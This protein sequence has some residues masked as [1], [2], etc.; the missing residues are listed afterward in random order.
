MKKLTLLMALIMLLSVFNVYGAVADSDL[1][2]SDSKFI[3]KHSFLQTLKPVTGS[4]IPTSNTLPGESEAMLSFPM[5]NVGSGGKLN[6]SASVLSFYVDDGVILDLIVRKTSDTTA[7]VDYKIRKADGSTS[8]TSLE[9]YSGSIGGYVPYS[10]YDNSYNDPTRPTS[11]DN[12]KPY[13][14]FNIAPGTGF[15]FKYNGIVNS[16]KWDEATDEF[17]FS[18]DGFKKGIVYDIELTTYNNSD[19]DSATKGYTTSKK[20]IS[21]LNTD[22]FTSVPFA[23]KSNTD[24]EDKVYDDY[25]LLQPTGATGTDDADPG[26]ENLGVELSLLLPLELDPATGN[27]SKV[28]DSSNNMTISLMLGSTGAGASYTKQINLENSLSLSPTAEGAEVLKD[29]DKIDIILKDM[30]PGIIYD[31]VAISLIFGAKDNIFTRSEVK[32][33]SNKIYTLPRYKII[34]KEGKCYVVFTPFK[35]V[36]GE[37]VLETGL[38]PTGMSPSITQKS[39]GVGDLT[40]PTRATQEN[41]FEYHYK[42]YF[43]PSNQ[44]IG[45]QMVKYK[46]IPATGD[47][48]APNNFTVVDYNLTTIDGVDNLNEMNLT[49]K[50]RWDIGYKSQIL[51]MLENS[52]TGAISVDYI[53]SENLTANADS[54]SPFANIKLDIVKVG[55]DIKVT[56]TSVDSLGLADHQA[57]VTNTEQVPLEFIFRADANEDMF[58]AEVDLE[59]KAGGRSSLL[60]DLIFNYPNIYFLTVRAN[61]IDRNIEGS[62]DPVPCGDQSYSA[63]QSITLDDVTDNIV[64]PPQKV[65]VNNITT[66]I[67]EAS[68]KLKEVSFKLNW[69]LAGSNLRDYLR[70]IY[71]DS[72]LKDILKNVDNSTDEIGNDLKVYY[73]I[74]MSTDENLM[75]NTFGNYDYDESGSTTYA[76]KTRQGESVELKYKSNSDNKIY[77]SDISFT[78][79]VANKTETGVVPISVLRNGKILRVSQVPI[80]DKESQNS[81]LQSIYD[82]PYNAA[83]SL[84][85]DGLDANAKYY[86]Y[87]DLVVEHVE[88]L[89][90]GEK[91]NNIVASLLSPLIGAT[92]KAI[93]DVPGY[94]SKIPTTPT[95]ELIK[96]EIDYITTRWDKIFITNDSGIAESVEYQIIRLKDLPMDEKYLSTRDSFSDTW[97]KYLPNVEKK[98]Y[99]TTGSSS[100][101]ISPVYP[102]DV[103]SSG[104]LAAEAT[105]VKYTKSTTDVEFFNSGLVANTVY[106]YYVRSVKT[107]KDSDGNVLKVYSTWDRVS[108]TTTNVKSPINLKIDRSGTGYDPYTEAILNFEAAVGDLTLL[109]S[110]VNIQYSYKE[111][112]GSWS[113]PIIMDPTALANSGGALN[114][115]GY[116]SFF[117]KVTGLKPGTTYTFKV[118]LIDSKSQTSMYSNE[119]ITKT[120]LDQD[121]YDNKVDTG[122]WYDLL[123]SILKEIID[124]SYWVLKD[125]SSVKEIIYREDKLEGILSKV[126]DETLSLADAKS[127]AQNI[128]Y[129]PASMLE[130]INNR[131]LGIRILYENVEFYLSPK[132]VTSALG[133]IKGFVNEKS[134]DDYYLKIEVDGYDYANVNGNPSLSDN[135]SFDI[136]TMGYNEK[137]IEWEIESYNKLI[138]LLEN[139]DSIKDIKEKI[140]EKIVD[141]DTNVE[142]Q[143]YILSKKDSLKAEFMKEIQ[144][145]FVE[146]KAS[147]KYHVDITK[148]SNPMAVSLLDADLNTNVSGFMNISSSWV[149]QKVMKLGA[150]NTMS[151]LTDGV[152]IFSGVKVSL[153]GLKGIDGIGDIT[154]IYSKYSFDKYLGNGANFNP[155]ASLNKAMLNGTVASMLGAKVG[156]DPVEFLR[157]SGINVSSRNSNS[158]VRA[159]ETIYML[160]KVYEKKTN[161]KMETFNITNFAATKDMADISNNNRKSVEV[162]TELKLVTDPTFNGKKSLT[163]KDYLELINRLN[164]IIK[165]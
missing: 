14:A 114:G 68:E 69:E 103:A 52:S 128:Y 158:N 86:I 151:V 62:Q 142:L 30:E 10:T 43:N 160:M 54:V 143:D 152:F 80:K 66:T 60:T 121:D 26:T 50:L 36:V 61:T 106:F 130:E 58:Y 18:Y 42:V 73:N 19:I 126:K 99:E 156:D 159:D 49:M 145:S 88:Y 129:I 32:L 155:N 146:T 13:P 2:T 82:N 1:I 91:K 118:R 21:G 150:K 104:F 74:Y 67:D 148:L 35:G 109:G 139:D 47:I 72:K 65:N 96:A 111:E 4:D 6:T 79:A 162:A 16:I 70:K 77:M 29:N 124:D 101:G 3:L 64:P 48:S 85:F 149:Q 110:G 41:G 83:K 122:K 76:P 71:V 131:Q 116:R 59:Y 94:E 28:L 17:F 93:L 102:Y 105:D 53:L 138:D 38:G 165:L 164:K 134:I 163:V 136:G 87:V 12:S 56:Y 23:S 25:I 132:A 100:S 90:N 9:I 108:G 46:P 154:D 92:T 5:T 141:G 24:P 137:I 98:G 78:G 95:I 8:K 40:F 22:T 144:K 34:V 161:T 15:S 81:I 153:D 112:D 123:K 27:Y 31:D 135:I 117:Y 89:N 107:V 84:T 7:E 113:E 140:L 115:D 157:K 44:N 147:S 125:S 45:S 75:R 63:F 51:K 55:D 20:I 39:D 33:E 119:A 97:N 120:E 57:I 11:F 37:Y 127:G 133:S